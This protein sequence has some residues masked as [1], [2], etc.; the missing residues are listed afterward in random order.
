MKK[1]YRPFII[2]MLL[3]CKPSTSYAQGDFF[4]HLAGG[5]GNFWSSNIL[6]LP[7]GVINGLLSGSF[8]IPANLNARHLKIKNVADVKNGAVFGF[9]G[10]DLFNYLY[11]GIRFGWQPELSWFGIFVS[12]EYEHQRFKVQ[13]DTN[14]DWERYKLHGIRPGIG[15]RLTPCLSLLE[16]SGW[17]PIIEIGTNYNYFVKCKAPYDNDMEQFNNGMSTTWGIGARFKKWSISAR[18]EIDHFNLFNKDYTPDDLIFPY[19]DV[20]TKS[21]MIFISVSHDF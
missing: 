19:K 9:K 4:F 17:S 1:I 10:D 18:A 7:T 6:G 3:F 11:Y 15:I 8:G 20:T 13:F 14:E 5:G 16:D 2:I 12:C 21:F